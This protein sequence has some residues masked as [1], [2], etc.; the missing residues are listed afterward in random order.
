[1]RSEKVIE[2]STFFKKCEAYPT[3]Q[4]TITFVGFEM[5]DLIGVLLEGVVAAKNGTEKGPLVCVRANVIE[6]IVPFTKDLIA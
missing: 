3:R 2:Y 6:K 4:E 5:F 1:M